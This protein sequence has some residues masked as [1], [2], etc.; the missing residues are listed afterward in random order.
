MADY[1]YDTNNYDLID[2]GSDNKSSSA[3]SSKMR[4]SSMRIEADQN[5]L[6]PKTC[7]RYEDI[8]NA[9]L[10]HVDS[11]RGPSGH[12]TNALIFEENANLSPDIFDDYAAMLHESVFGYREGD[13]M[14][15]LKIL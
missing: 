12:Q 14:K 7:V 10:K 5:M 13:L 15:W 9:F 8:V 3:S 11:L 1:I 6:A 2:L 4:A